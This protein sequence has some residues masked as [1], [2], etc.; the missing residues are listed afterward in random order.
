M[1]RWLRCPSASAAAS[2]ALRQGST[3]PESSCWTLALLTEAFRAGP[4]IA[5]RGPLG[6]FQGTAPRGEDLLA[7]VPPAGLD[8]LAGFRAVF[9][10]ELI[11]RLADRKGPWALGPTFTGSK[12]LH[13]DADLIAAGLL[14]DLKTTAKPALALT[15]M[16]Q[17][18][19]YAMLDFDDAYQLDALGVFNARHAQLATWDLHG[20]L[21][22]LAGHAVTLQSVR[23]E[24]KGLLLA[25]QAKR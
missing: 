19:G 8:Q 3:W 6:R 22:E 9:E 24:F 14:L 7:L 15:D 11:P 16:L 12:L 5:L 23:D 1:C 20:L 10:A 2:T 21:D 17:L 25:H 13:A 4:V 18:V